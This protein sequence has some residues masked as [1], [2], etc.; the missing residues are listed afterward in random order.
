MEPSQG[1][2]NGHSSTLGKQE[3]DTSDEIKILVGSQIGN[4]A[5]V[6]FLKDLDVTS[7]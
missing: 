6:R 7:R 1:D 5:V 4:G 3:A 2:R